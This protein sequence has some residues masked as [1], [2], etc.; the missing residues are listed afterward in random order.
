MEAA[1]G[2]SAQP[3]RRCLRTDRAFL[4]FRLDNHVGISNAASVAFCTAIIGVSLSRAT[5]FLRWIRPT[6][7]SRRAVGTRQ[8]DGV[9][10]GI[11]QPKLP[12]VRTAIAGRRIAMARHQHLR[13]H[14]LRPGNGGVEVLELE[15]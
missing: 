13:V 9:S 3:L 7:L 12:V 1:A 10:V 14:L 15:P 11:A 6:L 4:L 5:T 8:D 2:R